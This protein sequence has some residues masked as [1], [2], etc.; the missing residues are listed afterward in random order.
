MTLLIIPSWVAFYTGYRPERNV[1][2]IYTPFYWNLL[3]FYIYP[4]IPHAPELLHSF[5]LLI[6]V[7]VVK[8]I[9]LKRP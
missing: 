7:T 6:L 9:G 5:P 3:L 1:V 4:I 8:G 2:N